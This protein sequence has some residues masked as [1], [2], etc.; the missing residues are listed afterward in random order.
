MAAPQN[1][2]FIAPSVVVGS[3]EY[4]PKYPAGIDMHSDRKTESM[5]KKKAL[6]N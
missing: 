6:I 3:S 2:L 5:P 4:K 1:A